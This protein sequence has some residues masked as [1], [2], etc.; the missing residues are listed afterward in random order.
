MQNEYSRGGGVYPNQRSHSKLENVA[1]KSAT[2]R[3]NMLPSISV[4]D[5]GAE[6]SLS[7]T[8]DVSGN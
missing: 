3:K 8:L 6:V 7:N 1:K 5:N 4:I 2:N